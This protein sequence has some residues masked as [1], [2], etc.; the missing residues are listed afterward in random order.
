MYGLQPLTAITPEKKDKSGTRY[1]FT[2]TEID[3]LTRNAEEVLQFHEHM[4]EEMRCV[5]T[6]LGFT[7]DFVGS[8]EPSAPSESVLANLEIGLSFVATKFAT[9]VSRC[10][11]L[12]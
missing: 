6:P 2:N 11:P 5:L 10:F 8:S 9:E 4:V 12:N 1:L 7:M 3:Q